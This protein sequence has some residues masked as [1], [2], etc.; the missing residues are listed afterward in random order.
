[1]KIKLDKKQSIA[2]IAI[3]VVG[4]VLAGFILFSGKH[5]TGGDEHG[6]E[7]SHQ[8]ES[9]QHAEGEKAKQQESAEAK[10]HEE[11]IVLSDEQI[12]AAGITLATADTALIKTGLI[13]PGE[14][15]F[16]EDRTAHVVPRLTGVVQSV[17]AELGQKIKKGQIL[18]VIAS[19]DLSEQRSELFS[20]QK[21]M[22]LARLTFDREKKLWEEKISAEQ[23][24]LQSQQ[25]LREAEIAVQNAN[26]KLAALG[27]DSGKTG[28]FNRYEIR[29]PFD[30]LVVA[31]HVTLGEVVKED[32]SIFT[33]S[34]LSSVWTEIAVSAKDLN[35][36]RV[37]EKVIVKATAFD[38]TSTGT[39][40][41]VGSLLG[42]QTRTAKARVTL[43]N[44]QGTWRP[45]LF[46]NVEIIASEVQ[47][48]VSVAADAVHS[49]NDKAIV[50]V[51]VADGFIAQE[52]TTGRSDTQKI[53]ITKG[54]KVGA[55]Y[56]AD[57]SF[58]VKSELGKAS[59]EHSH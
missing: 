59:A 38:S 58:I 49:I 26:Q 47:V 16:N 5:K 35:T 24:Y 2:I 9:H 57:S 29:A 55:Q 28:A 4:L 12:K 1:M 10:P 17:P 37:G 53:E 41:Y 43:A 20:A 51:K 30:G 52:V 39:I 15:Q 56:A 44:P 32:A 14:I 42:E 23:D 31:K 11:K 25:V 21:R 6:H 46:V 48:P 50:F 45:G 13:L 18:A 7:E 34:D 40:A 27:A 19:T 8:E 22:A 33:I 54:L 3:V 36:V